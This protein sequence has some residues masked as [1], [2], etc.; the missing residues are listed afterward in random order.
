MG[1]HYHRRKN[2]SKNSSFEFVMDIIAIVGPAVTLPQLIEI[3]TRGSD[4][5]VSLITWGGYLAL[6]VFW[7]SYGIMKKEKPIIIA[8]SL[9]LVINSIIVVGLVVL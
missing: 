6:S 9:Y 5:G 8:N 7:L 2:K 3:W 1:Q 4:A